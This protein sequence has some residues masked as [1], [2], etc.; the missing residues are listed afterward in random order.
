MR[1]VSQFDF[2]CALLFCF[3]ISVRRATARCL[4]LFGR[5]GVLGLGPE[6]L[7]LETGSEGL[8]TRIAYP[9][10]PSEK[11]VVVLW[12]LLVAYWD[13]LFRKPFTE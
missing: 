2:Q 13:P 1:T 11:P 4:D 8:D 7:G 3:L 10:G 6:G 12:S 9:Q 5:F